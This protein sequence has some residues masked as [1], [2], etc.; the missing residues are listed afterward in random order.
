M[1]SIDNFSVFFQTFPKFPRMQTIFNDFQRFKTIALKKSC[2][3]QFQKFN[4]GSTDIIFLI[5]PILKTHLI[6]LRFFCQFFRFFPVFFMTDCT[7]VLKTSN[8]SS[9]DN[10]QHSTMALLIVFFL[11]FSVQSSLTF[12]PIKKKHKKTKQNKTK[13]LAILL[14]FFS[15]KRNGVTFCFFC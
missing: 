1:G 10:F 11:T 7:R 12:Q 14:V 2:Y 15:E 8:N 13:A 5:L 3:Y 4:I 9:I 6:F